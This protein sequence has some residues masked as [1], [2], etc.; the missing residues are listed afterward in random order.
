MSKS[1]SS[2]NDN[3]R[4]VSASVSTSTS[5]SRQRAGAGAGT[6]SNDSNDQAQVSMKVGNTPTRIPTRTQR[7]KSDR[8]ESF[9]SV[10]SISGLTMPCFEESED[11]ERGVETIKADNHEAKVEVEDKAKEDHDQDAIAMTIAALQNIVSDKDT[12]DD[13]NNHGNDDASVSSSDS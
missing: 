11:Q 3:S 7:R 8:R 1:G 10:H 12:H 5:T 2:D 9:I 6:G 4:D 13:D